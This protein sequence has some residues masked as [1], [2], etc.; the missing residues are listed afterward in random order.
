MVGGKVP[1]EKAEAVKR[2]T[3]EAKE[4]ILK[5]INPYTYLISV[6]VQPRQIGSAFGKI[7]G[8]KVIKTGEEAVIKQA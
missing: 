5:Q 6:D 7:E 1:A 4:K 8:L 3:H 2:F